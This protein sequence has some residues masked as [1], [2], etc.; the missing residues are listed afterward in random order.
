MVH[1]STR[2]STIGSYDGTRLAITV[3]RP[4][5][6]G[7]PVDTRMPIIVTQDR[8]GAPPGAAR[9]MRYYTDRGYVWIAQDRR[10]TGASFGVQ[11]GFVT[12]QDLRDAA[13]VIE[14]AG[15]QRFSNGKVV[16]LGCSNQGLWQYGVAALHPKY[17]VAIA[18]ACA[19]PQFFDDGISRN[20]IPLF[21]AGAK[22]YAGEC[23][24]AGSP[25]PGPPRPAP[26]AV[27]VA[28]DVHGALLAAARKQQRCD[29]L[30]MGEPLATAG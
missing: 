5:K 19:S 15:A 6:G 21:P 27:P 10:G 16:T 12:R 7:Q 18:P 2:L 9:R 14:W 17:L 26:A 8:T 23:G 22:P 1:S 28:A 29:A 3:H 11:A 30:A 24:A 13:A 4:T 20:D 25:M